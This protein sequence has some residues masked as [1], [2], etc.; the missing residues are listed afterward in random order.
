[1]VTKYEIAELDDDPFVTSRKSTTVSD[2][3]TEDDSDSGPRPDELGKDTLQSE[4]ATDIYRPDIDGLRAVA[5]I[6]V[7]IYHMEE[8]WLP[9]GFTGVDIFF[10][11][12]GYVV[13]SSLSRSLPLT[14]DG[15]AAFYARRLKRLL[16]AHVTVTILTGFA[17]SL[18]VPPW[19]EYRSRFFYSGMLALVGWANNYFATLHVGY[20]DEGSASL[21]MNPF[22]HTWSLGV[23]EQYYMLVPLL[24]AV[25]GSRYFHGPTVPAIVYGMSITCSALVSWWLTVHM[26]YQAFYVMPAR[27]WEL[28]TGALLFHAQSSNHGYSIDEI[29]GGYIHVTLQVA[30]TVSIIAS[31]VFTPEDHGFP[32]P[33]AMLPVVGTLFFITAGLMPGSVLNACIGW[34]PFVFVGK[35]SYPM[36]LLHWPVFVLCKWSCGLESCLVR[37]AS[38]V[39][40]LLVALVIYYVLERPI[41]SWRP[42]SP[43]CFIVSFLAIALAESCLYALGSNMFGDLYIG[44]HALVFGPSEQHAKHSS[45]PSSQTCPSQEA[46][47]CIVNISTFHR[48]SCGL[49]KS[50]E[51]SRLLSVMP[52]CVVSITPGTVGWDNHDFWESD[53]HVKKPLPKAELEALSQKCLE[54]DRGRDVIK[55]AM[56]VIG[57][58]H[59]GMLVDGLRDR[60]GSQMSIHSFRSSG[61]WCCGFCSKESYPQGHFSADLAQEG[62]AICEDFAQVVMTSLRSS[63]RR[64]DIVIMN[65]YGHWRDGAKGTTRTQL[66]DQIKALS[67]RIEELHGIVHSRGANLVIV[68]PSPVLKKKGSEC[69]GTAFQPQEARECDINATASELS[70]RSMADSYARLGRKLTGTLFFDAHRLLC[71]GAVCGAR[72]PGTDVIGFSDA[73][74]VSEAGSGYLAQFLCPAL[75]SL[76]WLPNRSQ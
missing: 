6:S 75:A 22:T 2:T 56:F 16:P 26:P 25:T 44:K 67:T 7:V 70:Y 17:M 39:G 66:S 65:N 48:S 8:R 59:A 64:G 30:A 24:L 57:D 50:S 49:V 38:V 12:S 62:M 23:E 20:F 41:R 1:M 34:Q 61:N 37:F 71:D 36:Y 51:E 3:T 60:F 35:L 76:G 47:G 42:T 33:A 45:I 21:K 46:C 31:L 43:I 5:V 27:F 29:G 15:L 55:T 69:V 19:E 58:S 14:L 28:M 72:I 74:H 52:A 53:C 10:V 68:G 9:G 18:L 73:H 13:M 4:G 11:I 54:P 32:F 63:L 40:I